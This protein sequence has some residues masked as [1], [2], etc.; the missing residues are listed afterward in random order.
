MRVSLQ[1]NQP[2]LT[3]ASDYNTFPVSDRVRL[4]S[5]AIKVAIKNSIGIN[6]NKSTESQT[7]S[8]TKYLYILNIK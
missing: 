4:V 6:F 8:Y 1:A 2:L 7:N 3:V 5:T